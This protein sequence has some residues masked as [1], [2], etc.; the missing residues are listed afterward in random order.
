MTRVEV[1]DVR[2]VIILGGIDVAAGPDQPSILVVYERPGQTAPK[3]GE[4]KITRGDTVLVVDSY[5]QVWY[6][7]VRSLLVERV[8]SVNVGL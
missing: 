4:E 8:M 6:A 7:D 2:P 1:V 3:W 5:I